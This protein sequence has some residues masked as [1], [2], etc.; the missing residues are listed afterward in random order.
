[1]RD[2]L[3]GAAPKE[4]VLDG[5]VDAILSGHVAA[6]RAAWPEIDLPDEAFVAH[7]GARLPADDTA[8]HTLANVHAADLWLA[9]ACARGDARALRAFEDRYGREIPAALSRM[10]AKEERIDE[11]KQHV[12]EKLFVARE[13]ALPKIAD[14]S[15]RGPL[16]AWLRAVVVHAAVSIERKD[17][18]EPRPAG[19]D[20]EPL[21][22]DAAVDPELDRI[23]ARYAP[24]F[25]EAFHESLARL[26]SQERNVLRLHI[27]DGLN[28]GQI[29][30]A[31]GVHRA[32]VGRWIAAAREKLIGG[33]EEALR[34][35]FGANEAEVRSL[36]RLCRSHVDLSLLRVLADERA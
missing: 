27:V 32:T 21:A 33:T 26:T 34:A 23:R 16:V 11:V 1:M 35:K 24:A 5:D 19:D 30:Q 17:R 36:T 8:S 4:A 18:L 2:V 3:L 31:Y 13:G 7:V 14:Y 20:D 28:I 29:G 25:K 10:R 15:G 9:L 22:D 6:A 12:M